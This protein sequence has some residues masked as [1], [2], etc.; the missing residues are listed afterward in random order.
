MTTDTL[1]TDSSDLPDIVNAL[2]VSPRF[3]EDGI[4]FAARTSGLYRS[5]DGG[6]S[7]QP[8]YGSLELAAPLATMA[9]AVSPA[10]DADHRLFAG[11]NGGVLRSLDGGTTW[12]AAILASPEPLV[13][14]LAISPDFA[15][16]GVVLAG[17]MEDGVFRSADRGSSWA[18]WNFGL[19]DLNILSLAI[20][21]NF[22]RDETLFA[23]TESGLFRSTNGGR[24]WREVDF[25]TEFA[26]VLSLALSPDYAGDGVLFV[27]TEFHGLFSTDDRGGTWKR[28][29]EG[30]MDTAVNAVILSSDF[31]S[32]PDVLVLLSNML[33]I[34]R[35]GGASWSE[36]KPGLRFEESTASIAAPH[37][38]GP[39]APLLVGLVEG[40]VVR[41]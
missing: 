29:G 39:G 18:P 15:Y 14:A 16:D 36:W 25:P 33:L 23:G 8:T 2:A 27:G 26:P 4:C 35:D 5:D 7:W 3:E 11:V 28:R 19:L 24:A 32:R 30:V 37:G 31:P 40:G 34:S 21:P 13:T 22:A 1:F 41:L 6:R 9:V 12:S 38:L 10:F 17:T 20:S